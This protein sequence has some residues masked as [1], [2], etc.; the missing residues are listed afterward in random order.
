MSVDRKMYGFGREFPGKNSLGETPFER[1]MLFVC[2][3]VSESGSDAFFIFDD[4]PIMQNIC[5]YLGSEE[6]GT[7]GGD[8]HIGLIT[9]GVHKFLKERD[10]WGVD[11]EVEAMGN[12]TCE[13]RLSKSNGLRS[14]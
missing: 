9:C 4:S 10:L 14:V 3:W 11:F 8:N 7:I 13:V 1:E 5:D 2:R 6:V 12:G